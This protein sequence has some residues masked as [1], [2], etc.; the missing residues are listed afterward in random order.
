MRVRVHPLNIAISGSRSGR[1]E[2]WRRGCDRHVHKLFLHRIRK[3]DLVGL[4]VVQR[5]IAVFVQTSESTS[6]SSSSELSSSEVS[7]LES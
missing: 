6:E 1:S 5:V 3:S 7:E 2:C 4:G